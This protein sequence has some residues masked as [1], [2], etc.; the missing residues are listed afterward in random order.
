MARVGSESQIGRPNYLEFLTA[1]SYVV[2]HYPYTFK[3]QLKT[4]LFATAFDPHYYS[5]IVLDV[6][7]FRWSPSLFIWL[8]LILCVPIVYVIIIMF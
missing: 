3:K 4:R 5:W 7:L 1:L 2:L 6:P 8:S